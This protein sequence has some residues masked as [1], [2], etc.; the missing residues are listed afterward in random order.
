MVENNHFKFY[1]GAPSCVPATT[2]ET[3]GAIID[4]EEVN[5]L[6]RMPDIVYLTEMMNYPGVLID[7]EEV[8]EKISWAHNYKKPS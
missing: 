8:I 7:D 2:F 5:E 4:A 6:L 3:A 1:F